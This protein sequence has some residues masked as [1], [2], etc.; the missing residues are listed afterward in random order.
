MRR[1]QSLMPF[2]RFEVKA[3]WTIKAEE[4]KG[5]SYG[6]ELLQTVGF[7][8]SSKSKCAFFFPIVR[9]SC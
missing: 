3:M 2:F 7:V 5:E 6:T 1:D 8:Y 9:A 4:L